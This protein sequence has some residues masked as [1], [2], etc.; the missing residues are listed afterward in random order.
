MKLYFD[1]SC[2]YSIQI[3]WSADRGI[4]TGSKET[5]EHTDTCVAS[6]LERAGFYPQP[7][8]EVGLVDEDDE[9]LKTAVFDGMD[10]WWR[11]VLADDLSDHG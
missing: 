4:D 3:L 2:I 6:A 10:D 11:S 1:P 5:D 7:G 8:T 9:D